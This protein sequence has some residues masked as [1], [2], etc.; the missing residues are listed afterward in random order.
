[1]TI[2]EVNHQSLLLRLSP[3]APSYVYD[4]SSSNFSKAA[5]LSAPDYGLDIPRLHGWKYV[6]SPFDKGGMSAV[7]GNL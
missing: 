1:M 2:V 4:W 6:G 7:G 3:R 5:D